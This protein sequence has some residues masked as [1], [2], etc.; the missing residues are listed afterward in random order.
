M[1]VAKSQVSELYDALFDPLRKDRAHG[2]A[3][4]TLGDQLLA[5]KMTAAY[6]R[7]RSFAETIDRL[8]ELHIERNS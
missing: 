7:N 2:R 5:A 8:W 6:V 1:A 3:V 4:I